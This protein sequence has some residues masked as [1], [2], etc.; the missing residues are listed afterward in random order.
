MEK[1][2]HRQEITPILPNMVAKLLEKYRKANDGKLPTHILMFRDG[3]G[4]TMF[5]EV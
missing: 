4:I 2:K 3:V 1:Q 5:D